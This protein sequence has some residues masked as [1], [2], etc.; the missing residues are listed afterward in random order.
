MRIRGCRPHLR[1]RPDGQYATGGKTAWKAPQ[2]LMREPEDLPRA[3][4]A[5]VLPGRREAAVFFSIFRLGQPRRRESFQRPNWV[6]FLSRKVFRYGECR[7]LA[8]TARKKGEDYDSPR[9]IQ[10]Q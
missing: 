6:V 9:E 10:G 7:R 2:W 8:G 1:T 3:Y 5:L 4:G